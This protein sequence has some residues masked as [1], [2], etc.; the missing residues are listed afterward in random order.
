MFNLIHKSF[1]HV[2]ALMVHVVVFFWVGVKGSASF[3]VNIMV[4]TDTE[5]YSPTN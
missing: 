2:F 5:K 4:I 1:V 3:H